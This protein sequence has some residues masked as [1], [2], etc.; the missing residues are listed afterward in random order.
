MKTNWT[1]YTA[2]IVFMFVITGIGYVS[3]RQRNPVYSDG[4][5]VLGIKVEFISL[6]LSI[7]FDGRIYDYSTDELK[8]GATLYDLLRLYNNENGLTIQIK[9]YEGGNYIYKIDDLVSDGKNWNVYVNNKQYKGF[10][11]QYYLSNDDTVR[12]IWEE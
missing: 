1:L 3:Y 2:I 12:I 6:D 10:Y 8:P 5:T 7:E 4:A 11:S 9:Q